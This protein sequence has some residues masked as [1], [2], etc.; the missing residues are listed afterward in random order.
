MGKKAGKYLPSFQG[1]GQSAAAKGSHFSA[2]KYS[3]AVEAI[4]TAF[5]FCP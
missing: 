5:Y 3:E 4:L 1:R 2:V